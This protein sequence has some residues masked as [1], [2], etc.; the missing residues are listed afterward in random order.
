VAVGSGQI[1]GKGIGYGTQ[2]KLRFLPEYQTD[3]IFASYAEEW[4]LA[5]VILLIGLFGVVIL[6][7]LLIAVHGADN[8][9]TLFATGI[10]IYLTA[11]FIVHAG[12]NLGLL[13]ITGST[14]PFM[15]YG[16]SHLLTEFLAL[17]VLM[18][19]R[20]RGSPAQDQREAELIGL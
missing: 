19:L 1:F 9:D 13:P 2:S 5:G 11:Q 20:G 4:G 14:L 12:M 18:G 6:R 15:S 7:I 10:A 16:G 3:F 8:F 17:G